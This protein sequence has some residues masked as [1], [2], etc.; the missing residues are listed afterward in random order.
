MVQNRT[1]TNAQSDANIDLLPLVTNQPALPASFWLD[2]DSHDPLRLAPSSHKLVHR[3]PALL[4]DLTVA[5]LN[6]DVMLCRC[7]DCGAPMT[8]RLW[9]SVADCWHCGISIALTIEQ[10]RALTQAA[11]STTH[12]EDTRRRAAENK[13]ERDRDTRTDR[14]PP[15]RREVKP[16]TRQWTR[17]AGHRPRM[18]RRPA[19]ATHW[20]QNLPAWIVS[21]ILHMIVLALLALLVI[22][23][24]RQDPSLV[25]S[26]EVSPWRKEG[27]PQEADTTIDDV[28][29][30]LPIPPNVDRQSEPQR[31]A[32]IRADQAA[33][34]LRLDPLAPHPDLPD[35]VRVKTTIVRS[36]S[37]RAML[38]AR[39]P[40][41]RVEMI[42]Q[43][44]GTT[45]T[46]AAVARGLRW[47]HL[48]QSEDGSWSLDRFQ[49]SGNCQSRCGEPGRP[50]SDTA[51]TA[52]VLLPF[53]GAGQTHLVGHYQDSV[54]LGLRWL[55]EHQESNGDLRADSSGNSGMYAHGQA[56][57][58]LCEA[59]A[60]TGDA[61]LREAAQRSIDFIVAAQH[62]S[63]GW[64]YQPGQPGD[65]SVLGWQ[66]MALQSARAAELNVPSHTLENAGHFLDS[67]GDPEG[68]H[69]AYI[70]G[71]R[72]TP[73]MT[74]EALLCRMYLG[75]EMS[76]VGLQIGINTLV[77]DHLPHRQHS[78]FYYWYYGTQVMHHAG[79]AAWRKW[80]HHMRDVL[81]ASQETSGHEAGSWRPQSDHDQ[82]GGRLYTTAL[83]TCTLEVY[84]RH[85]PI[86]RRLKLD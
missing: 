33:R 65:T 64:R 32:L 42:R 8:L 54:S 24:T 34:Q 77:R 80:N 31:L 19:R 45:L 74:A 56:A 72:P 14:A 66:L 71:Q 78:N 79:G 69:Y 21:A 13:I 62:E 9:L 39:D 29:F 26:T 73:V 67:V 59:Y 1:T 52:L 36:D 68:A 25:I 61:Q 4:P 10:V 15:T 20:L 38:A 58:V 16:R 76:R 2:L 27:G 11:R 51:G 81:V 40:R 63:G 49:H 83:A 17:S 7:P 70:Q 43:E 6:G 22:E 46:E 41:V 28:R 48:H 86:F 75:W 23:A 53:L 37:R 55:I 85:V 5:P 3:P 60:M 30:D 44:G 82:T 57:I 18:T 35:L 50:R 47:L 12:Q 84:Y